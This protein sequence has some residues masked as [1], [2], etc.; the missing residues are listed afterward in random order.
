[1]GDKRLGKQPAAEKVPLDGTSL[2]AARIKAITRR[3][4]AGFSDPRVKEV[5]MMSGC[6]CVEVHDPA[7]L[8]GFQQFAYE[9]SV[10]S[11]PFL[12]YM[13]AMVPYVIENAEPVQVLDTMKAWVRR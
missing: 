11:R 1:M 4:M 12:C 2:T 13:Y 3:E 9:R 5:R 7:T 6:V 10:F 8:Q